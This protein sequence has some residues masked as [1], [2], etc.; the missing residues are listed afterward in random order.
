VTLWAVGGLETPILLFLVTVTVLLA[1]GA[2][3]RPGLGRLC[4]VFF[5]A[6]LAFLTRFDAALFMLPIVLHMMW[7]SRSARDIALATL[8]GAVLPATWLA[9]SLGYYGDL[10]PTSYYSKRPRLLVPVLIGNGKYVL[11][12]LGFTGVVPALL[13]I[14]GLTRPR[15]RTRHV[16]RWLF[17]RFRE[18]WWLYAAIMAQL[19]YGLTMATTHM[20]FSFRSFVPY[21]PAFAI[22]IGDLA[23]QVGAARGNGSSERT[24]ARSLAVTAMGLVVFQAYQ[25]YYTHQRSV[26]GLSPWGEYRGGGVAQYVTFIEGLRDQGEDIRRHWATVHADGGRMPRI[27]TY[28]GGVVPYTFQESYIYETLVSFRHCRAATERVEGSGLWMRPTIDLRLAADYIHLITPRQGP[29]APQLPL[30][31]AL[32]TLISSHEITFDGSRERL[33]VYFNPAPEPHRWPGRVHDPCP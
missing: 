20:M 33:L 27:F 7:R 10:F 21:L 16:L 29:I 8:I 19:L 3:E 4:C 12:Y 24:V 2:A 23:R 1:D 30:P 14:L 18:R 13:V 25:L 26:N 31:E 11:A 17:A 9:V 28:A 15:G 22:L 5:L 32:Y 6:G